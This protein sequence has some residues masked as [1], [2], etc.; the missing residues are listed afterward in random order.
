MSV[1]SWTRSCRKHH[2]RYSEYLDVY[3]LPIDTPCNQAVQTMASASC[4]FQNADL[5]VAAN[6]KIVNPQP[7]PAPDGVLARSTQ[8]AQPLTALTGQLHELR[9][10][11]AVADVLTEVPGK[12]AR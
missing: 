6:P 2:F 11:A 9:R 12:R 3:V 5:S 1:R 7:I 10:S 8:P 4:K